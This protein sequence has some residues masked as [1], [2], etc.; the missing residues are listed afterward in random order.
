[1][2]KIRYIDKPVFF[3]KNVYDDEINQMIARLIQVKGVKSIYQLGSVSVPGISDIDII[4]VFHDNFQTDINPR[5]TL[6]SKGLYLYKHSLFGLHESNYYKA[7]EYT[8]FHNYNHLYGEELNGGSISTNEKDINSLKKQIALEFMLAN[9]ISLTQQLFYGVVKLRSLLLEAKAISFDLEFLGISN[10]KMN[11]LVDTIINWRKTWFKTSPSKL[12]ISDWL[13]SYYSELENILSDY[14]KKGELFYHDG[15]SFKLSK[16][17]QINNRSEF[18]NYHTGYYSHHLSR[19]MINRRLYNAINKANRFYFNLPIK[20]FPE[21]HI[22]QRKLEFE[23]KM[24][25]DAAKIPHFIPLM[26]SFNLK[27]IS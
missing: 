8:F 16:N 21:N 18:G 23:E 25:V 15:K 14:L 11:F 17:I 22:A 12:E 13:F 2:K 10:Q 20:S 3:D 1:M 24:I 27:K 4:V 7:Q 19:I 9:Y 6:N 5:A 26:N